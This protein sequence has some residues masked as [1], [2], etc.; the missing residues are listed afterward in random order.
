[1]YINTLNEQ[2]GWQDIKMDFVIELFLYLVKLQYKV[3]GF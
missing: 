1:M 3:L 2:N